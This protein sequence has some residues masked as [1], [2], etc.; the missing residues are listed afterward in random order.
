ML[1]RGKESEAAKKSGR[2]IQKLF[3]PRSLDSVVWDVCCRD[4]VCGAG[5]LIKIFTQTLGVGHKTNVGL[6]LSRIPSMVRL[7]AAPR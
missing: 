6:Y 1:G 3:C 7:V 2:M 5:T 4:E